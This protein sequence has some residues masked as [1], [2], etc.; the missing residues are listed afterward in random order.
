LST[1]TGPLAAIERLQAAINAHD[2]DALV[3]CFDP[4]LRSTQP[5]RPDRG[6]HGR[7]HLR[8]YW[9]AVFEGVKDFRGKLL[10]SSAAGNTVWAEWCW[11]GTREDGTTF[12]RAGV[13]IYGIA[14]GRIRWLRVYMEPVQGDPATIAEWAMQELWQD[15]AA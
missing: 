15:D 2:V 10:R 5:T 13:S 9:A 12:V 8:A 4:E 3:D 7:D 6:Y 1:I 14:E 11:K